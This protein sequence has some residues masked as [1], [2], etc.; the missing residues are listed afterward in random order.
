[1]LPDHLF[2]QGRLTF[3]PAPEGRNDNSPT[4][5]RWE[6][7]AEERKSRRDG[8]PSLPQIPLVIGNAVFLEQGQKLLLKGHLPVVLRLGLGVLNA[9]RSAVPAGLIQGRTWVPNVE[10]LGYCRQVPP[11]QRQAGSNPSAVFS[12]DR[13]RS[14]AIFRV[15]WAWLQ[16]NSCRGQEAGC[17]RRCSADA[18]TRVVPGRRAARGRTPARGRGGRAADR[19]RIWAGCQRA[20]CQGG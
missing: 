1:M 7:M 5:Q 16:A 13:P 14:G 20:G 8:S 15:L 9:R 18:H 2:P 10:T 6:P 17:H 12:A 11:G 19:N 3:F 4:F